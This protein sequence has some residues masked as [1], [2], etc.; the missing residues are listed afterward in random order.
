MNMKCVAA[1]LHVDTVQGN[2]TAHPDRLHADLWADFNAAIARLETLHVDM[3]T[4]HNTAIARL[5]HTLE[6]LERMLQDHP[7]MH[8]TNP[9]TR[10]VNIYSPQDDL[11]PVAHVA[12]FTTSDSSS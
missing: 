5:E 12:N 1:A 9:D 8:V 7:K 6:R 2:A 10:F 11:Y 3:L 4:A